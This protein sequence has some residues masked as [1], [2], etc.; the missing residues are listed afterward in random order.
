MNIVRTMCQIRMCIRKGEGLHFTCF[1]EVPRTVMVSAVTIRIMYDAEN[2]HWCENWS[3]EGRFDIRNV[4]SGVWTGHSDLRKT[5][6][7]A[8]DLR[9]YAN[10]V[11]VN[12]R[13]K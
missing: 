8:Y 12:R 5:R 9:T 4:R 6:Y 13:G 7:G 2:R 1:E 10:T 11:S 3:V